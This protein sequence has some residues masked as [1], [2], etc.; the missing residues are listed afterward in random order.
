MNWFVFYQKWNQV[1]SKEYLG[2]ENN[3]TSFNCHLHSA[4][5]QDA[6]FQV[7]SHTLLAA[8]PKRKGEHFIKLL[9]LI[10]S[11]I[12]LCLNWHESNETWK[13]HR[14]TLI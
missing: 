6:V 3:P 12:S 8:F 4:K 5:G 11:V 7:G 2:T 9:T 10:F 13:L 14:N 1:M